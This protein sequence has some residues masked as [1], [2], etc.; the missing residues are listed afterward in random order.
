MTVQQVS[1]RFITN[2]SGRGTKEFQRDLSTLGATIRKVGDGSGQSFTKFAKF[3]QAAGTALMVGLGG[4]L[5]IGIKASIDFEDAFAGVRKT[6]DASEPT[7]QRLA[8][9]IRDLALDIPIAV[10]E[11]ARIGEL[12]GQLGIPVDAL[13]EF[14]EVI[15]KLGVTT[16]LEVD[17]A[18]IALA[19]FANV[20]GSSTDEFDN[21]ASGLVELGNNFATSEK[22]ILGFATRLAGIGATIGLTEGDVLGLATA[23]TALGEP[24]ERGA[25]AVQRA[26]V[27]MFQAVSAGGEDLQIFAEIVG[28]TAEEFR[29]LFDEDPA[30]AFI[31]FA[32]GLQRIIDSGEDVTTILQEL[33][34]G[35]QR[36]LGAM[37]KAASGADVLAEAVNQGNLAF[38]DASALNEEA[39]KRFGTMASQI[40]ILKNQFTDLRIE[41][42]DKAAPAFK[43]VLGF[44]GGFL[45][46]IRENIPALQGFATLIAVLAGARGLG[47]LGQFLGHTLIGL[48]NLTPAFVKAGTAGQR[49]VDR[50]AGWVGGVRFFGSVVTIAALAIGG[51]AIAMARNRQLANDY[52][53][54]IKNLVK[55][56]MEFNREGATASEL[57]EAFETALTQRKGI[58]DDTIED[59][60]DYEEVLNRIGLTSRNLASEVLSDPTRIRERFQREID[61]LERELEELKTLIP[62]TLATGRPTSIPGLEPEQAARIGVIT[63]LLL[64]YKLLLE[65]VFAIEQSLREERLRQANQ[66]I[67]EDPALG[68][69]F[70]GAPGAGASFADLVGGPQAERIRRALME[71]LR[72]TS[73]EYFELLEDLTENTEGFADDFIDAWSDVTEDF[74]SLLFDWSSAWDGYEN[75]AAIST[76]E[77]KKSLENWV[78]DA[79]RLAEATRLV[80]E[81]LGT[82]AGLMFESLPEDLRRGLAASLAKG[83]EGLFFNQLSLILDA[84]SSLLE[85]ALIA[86]IARA[87]AGAQ[88]ALKTWETI[89]DDTVAKIDDQIDVGSEAWITTV[90]DQL[91]LLDNRIEEVFPEVQTAMQSL[92]ESAKEKL[93]TEGV[94]LPQ[95]LFESM[96][97]VDRIKLFHSLGLSWAEAI[98]LGFSILPS[99]L[100]TIVGSSTSVIDKVFKDGLRIES[101]SK[102]FMEY[103]K[104]TAE[105]FGIGLM[106][107]L[108]RLN[109]SPRQPVINIDMPTMAP[110]NG[111]SITLINPQHKDDDVL[112]GVKRATALIGL[113]RAAEVTPG[114]N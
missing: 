38:G 113:T 13:D 62:D 11:L 82:D 35:S 68:G 100:G 95:S 97:V 3:S 60:E 10:T 30:Q 67:I 94:T 86:A 26:F 85:Q 14:I 9:D 12:G 112:D 92:I 48:G 23:F 69:E 25:T 70:T 79:A 91:G 19:R 108:E 87:P 29:T 45:D 61:L 90:L 27:S 1:V 24:A 44:A 76:S 21:I 81:T 107:G 31:M 6:V 57:A 39:A 50:M 53:E 84:E 73:D 88:E 105:G 96:S 37:L 15:A 65:E 110:V 71:G 102:V 59:L 8:K 18:A 17:E 109:F 16:N 20:M 93:E 58:F 42:G 111:P 74:N 64:D 36:T 101:P 75:V 41:I 80:Y 7:F 98:A 106:S 28:V 78:E 2:Y 43:D 56:F 72:I 4:A 47:K 40:G 32:A 66:R 55:V 63:N 5:A 99:K 54:A 83:G 77:L 89:F 104:L 34:L 46:V 114:F 52:E 103:G 51:L 33:G 49:L 22:E